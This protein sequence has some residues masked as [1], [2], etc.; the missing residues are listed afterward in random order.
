MSLIPDSELLALPQYTLIIFYH[1][2]IVSN[3]KS[4]NR[5]INNL[6]KHAIQ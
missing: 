4:I 3:D 2:Q 1:L 5:K 6:N